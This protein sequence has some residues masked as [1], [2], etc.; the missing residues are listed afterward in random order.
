MDYLS[1][2]S[3]PYNPYHSYPQFY[4]HRHV[5]TQDYHINNHRTEPMELEKL[6]FAFCIQNGDCA[7][8]MLSLPYT[9]GSCDPDSW[10]WRM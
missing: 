8:L 5:F 10:I 9:A 2:F 7:A 1:N 4:L 3:P 6:V